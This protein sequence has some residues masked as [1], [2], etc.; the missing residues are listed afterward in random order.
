M[1]LRVKEKEKGVYV[2]ENYKEL[3]VKFPISSKIT[4]EERY[5]LEYCKRVRNKVA[6]SPM[7]LGE[8]ESNL[9]SLLLKILELLPSSEYLSKIKNLFEEAQEKKEEKDE[10][11][12]SI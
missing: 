7:S 5:L 2:L 8:K 4:E 6:H 3:R 9:L 11:H 1:E 10:K 12:S